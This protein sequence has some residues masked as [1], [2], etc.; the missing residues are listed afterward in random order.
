MAETLQDAVEYRDDRRAALL[1]AF[2]GFRSSR[3]KPARLA[4][5]NL[6]GGSKTSVVHGQGRPCHEF[7]SG[8]I[9][10][11][12]SIDAR[13]LCSRDRPL[14]AGCITKEERANGTEPGETLTP[15]ARRTQGVLRLENTSWAELW[16]LYKK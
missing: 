1:L 4:T 6:E 12:L 9:S 3:G 8:C 15:L 10:E 13:A 2:R 16:Q 11:R 5:R 7:F 14:I